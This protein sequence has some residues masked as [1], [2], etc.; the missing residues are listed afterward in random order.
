[1]EGQVCGYGAECI[2]EYGSFKCKCPDGYSGDPQVICS[3]VHIVCISDSDCPTN[4]KC[5]QP[6]EC[7]CPPPYFT[8]S[9]DSNKCKS[10]YS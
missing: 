8:D 6:G 9:K 2:N 10:E 7:V 3:P 1:M 4:E 5:V